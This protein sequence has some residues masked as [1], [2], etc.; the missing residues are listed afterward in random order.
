MLL[1]FRTV[2]F[3]PGAVCTGTQ[4]SLVREILTTMKRSLQTLALVAVALA[5]LAGSG[6]SK[7]KAR[8]QLNK[9][10]QAYKGAKYEE[11]IS[12]FQQA[13]SLDPTLLNAR[14]YLATAYAQQYI[15][16]APGE[17][18]ER[19]A[20]QAID[21]FQKVLDMHPPRDQEIASL[22]GIASLYFNMKQLDKAKEYHQ[23]V[24]QMDP[25]DP[26]AYYSI[27]VIDWTES[28]QPNMEERAKLGLKPDE[29][30]KDKKV[31]DALQQ[32]NS[33]N[34]KEG[35]DALNKALTLRPD[36]D[37]AMAYMNLMYRQKA[38]L[39]CGDPA[40]RAADLKT[41]DEWVDKTMATKKAKA[42]KQPG[43]TGIVADQPSNK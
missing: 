34:V 30:I 41:A 33:D 36:Y 26:E 29:P 11:A 6:C 23:K 43:A 24:A 17:D 39:D 10:V 3:R 42:E 8:D 22:K 38:D 15:P 40:A 2:A 7:L 19:N 31:C 4:H 20:K 13:V 27:G 9:G 37:D 1:R 25:N 14:L 16:G 32:K 28:Y 5:L 12:H 21:E 35:I 18:N